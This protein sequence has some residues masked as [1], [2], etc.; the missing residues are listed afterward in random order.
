M[1]SFNS[2]MH[3]TEQTSGLC[4]FTSVLTLRLFNLLLLFVSL[5][6]SYSSSLYSALTTFH[7]FCLRVT[8]CVCDG[9][10]SQR[11]TERHSV[12]VTD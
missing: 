4:H 10:S 11:E 12:C 5:I 2:T 8:Q 3:L 7:S 1:S 9:L 6:C